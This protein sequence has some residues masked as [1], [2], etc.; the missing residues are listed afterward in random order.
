MA[1]TLIKQ[2]NESRI[3]TMSFEANLGSGETLSAVSS[4]TGSPDGLTIADASVSSD[5][6][7]AQARISDGTA[8]EGYK[9][10]VVATTSF[11]N[12]LEAEG[13]LVVK[14]L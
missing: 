8:G 13:A 9:I 5:G 1:Q 14:D 12:T 6:K 4:F 2:P 10:T 7:K 11:G 3:Y